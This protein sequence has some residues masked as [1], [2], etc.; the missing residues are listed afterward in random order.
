MWEYALLIISILLNIYYVYELFIKEYDLSN[1][2]YQNGR[3]VLKISSNYEMAGDDVRKITYNGSNNGKEIA[4]TADG[5]V[6]VGKNKWQH[7]NV[8]I[9]LYDN[10]IIFGSVNLKDVFV[11]PTK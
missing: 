3:G 6:R 8:T 4:I 11:N 7:G 1:G 10:Y 2:M 5:L 9:E